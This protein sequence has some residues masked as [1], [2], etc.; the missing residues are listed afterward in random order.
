MTIN[1]ILEMY[2]NVETY[3]YYKEKNHG[4][5]DNL[6]WSDSNYEHLTEE[7]VGVGS[8]HVNGNIEVSVNGD[9]GDIP[10]F[11][12]KTSDGRK[13]CLM[14]GDW[15]NFNHGKY[16]GKLMN[17]EIKALLIWLKQKPSKPLFAAS[18]NYGAICDLWNAANP[19]Q[20]KKFDKDK[21]PNYLLEQ[22]KS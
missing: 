19:E 20:Q 16:Q 12:F 3:E 1:E 2:G 18:T 13:G 6:V 14:I 10:H 7:E 5:N 4:R 9:E 21:I 11:H 15:H 8:F 22:Y 17:K